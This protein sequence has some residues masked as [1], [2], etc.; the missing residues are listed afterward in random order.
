MFYYIEVHL[1]DHYTQHSLLLDVSVLKGLMIALLEPKRAAS[2]EIIF[3]FT[4]NIVVVFGGVF[5]SV[6]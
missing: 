1:L 4:I 2:L 5:H 6:E 3:S